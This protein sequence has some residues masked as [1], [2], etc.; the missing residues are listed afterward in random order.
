MQYGITISPVGPAG[1]PRSMMELAVL[2]EQAGWDAMFLEDYVVY[3]DPLPT[4]DPWVV[5]AAM[6]VVTTRI[7]LGTLVTPIT[8]RRPWKVAMEGTTLDHLSGGRAILGI[9][10]G[11]AAELSFA[12]A[13]EPSSQRELAGR[14][15][16]ALELI[17]RL[18]EGGPVTYQGSHYRTTDLQLAPRPLQRPRIP[19]WIGGDWLRPGVRRRLPR[20]DGSC[21]YH[22]TP[23]TPDSRPLDADEVSE[24]LAWVRRVRGNAD[25]FDVCVGGRERDPDAGREREYLTSL[26][27]AGA[28]WWQE[29]C[30]PGDAD[31][32]R[33]AV[34]GGPLR[35]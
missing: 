32:T 13:G 20:W 16:E 24:L 21:A 31:R 12:A 34:E 1:D 18:W 23:G 30:R 6:A 19:I 15:D 26:A 4:Y 7:K 8:R 25:G 33:A 29:W 2:A 3:P 5:M 35:V 14:L 28:T 27:A 17:A 9:G 22:G 10:A 11:D